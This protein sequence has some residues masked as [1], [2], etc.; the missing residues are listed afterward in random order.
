MLKVAPKHPRSAFL[1]MVLLAGL[2]A[3]PALV[4]Q[5]QET[6]LKDR[7]F[8]RPDSTLEFVP[9]GT[10]GK[11]IKEFQAPN[12]RIK[13]FYFREVFLSKEFST[14]AF[15]SKEFSTAEFSQGTQS[16]VTTDWRENATFETKAAEGV[17]T[18]ATEAASDAEKTAPGAG[19]EYKTQATE[20]PGK[21]QGELDE[22]YHG[23]PAL[24]IDEVRELLNK[25]K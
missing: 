17:E 8:P 9:R 15:A 12:A 22:Q 25:N 14:K 16:Y 21:S 10:S 1:A 18:F 20:L 2:V 6:T 19:E 11:L 3:A 5:E 7:L 4:A 23:R 13:P 24:S